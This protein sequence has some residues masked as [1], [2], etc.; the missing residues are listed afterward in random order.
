MKEHKTYAKNWIILTLSDFC[1]IE[2]T[3]ET[4]DKIIFP[5]RDII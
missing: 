5:H 4:I 2:E 1:N 3:F